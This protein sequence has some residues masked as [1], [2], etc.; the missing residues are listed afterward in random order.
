MAAELWM[1]LRKV[2]I[3]VTIIITR[4]VY[5]VG[6][7]KDMKTDDMELVEIHHQKLPKFVQ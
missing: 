1:L 3:M 6:G 7:D 2:M 4:T 5:G